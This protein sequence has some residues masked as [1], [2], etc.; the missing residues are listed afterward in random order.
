MLSLIFV[1]CVLG[2]LAYGLSRVPMPEPFK[3]GILCVMVIVGLYYVFQAL[4]GASLSL[5]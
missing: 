2:V 3:T 4:G 5:R 1:L